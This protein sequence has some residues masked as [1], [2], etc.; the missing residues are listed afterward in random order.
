M[1]K[2]DNNQQENPRLETIDGILTLVDG[3]TGFSGDFT[4]LKKRL[5]HANLSHEMLIKAAKVRN[6]PMPLQVLDATAGMGEDSLLLAAA[7]YTV[8]LCE[9]N[10]VI[11]A[12]LEDAYKRALL[13][14]ELKPVAERMHVENRY[15]IKL[16]RS[17][18]YKP[19]IDYLDPMFPKRE[20]SSLV[21][22]KFQ[23]IHGL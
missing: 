13:D 10:P 15:S 17:D 11:Y 20:K 5:T 16:M 23:L 14:P 19:D 3:K 9:K 12:L 18:D 22:K 21:K 1:T 8:D 2:E 6:A 4:R 7:G